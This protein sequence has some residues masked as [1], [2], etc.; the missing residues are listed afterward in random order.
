MEMPLPFVEGGNL[1]QPHKT[2]M[3]IKRSPR[4]PFS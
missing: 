2:L 4:P 3:L 1:T